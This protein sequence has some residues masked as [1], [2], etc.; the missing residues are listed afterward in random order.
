MDSLFVVIVVL[1]GVVL[2]VR[3][4]PYPKRQAREVDPYE[5]GYLRGGS[6]SAVRVALVMAHQRGAVDSGRKGTVRRSGPLP[7]EAGRLERAAHGALYWPISLPMLAIRPPVERELAELRDRLIRAGLLLA[8]WQWA[9]ARIALC[10]VPPAGFVWLVRMGWTPPRLVTAVM[11][12]FA[13]VALWRLPRRTRRGSRVVRELRAGHPVPE[14]RAGPAPALS[15]YDAGMATA[16]HGKAALL[17]VAPNF[18]RD[19]GLLEVR[20]WVSDWL[21]DSSVPENKM[22]IDAFIAGDY[23]D[24]GWP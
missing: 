11:A 19:S 13:A 3:L 20:R 9:V 10:A 18:A 7:R 14:R 17:A 6:R 5:V 2:A 1:L 16:L 24:G 23:S 12:V 4:V 21:G 22:V 15:V 8:S